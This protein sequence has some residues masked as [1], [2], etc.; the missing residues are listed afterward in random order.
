MNAERRAEGGA[1]SGVA[2]ASDPGGEYRVLVA[3]GNPAHAEQLVRTAADLARREGGSLFVVSVVLK[4]HGS[5]VALLDD[6]VIVEEFSGDRREILD[7]AVAT[8]G[9]GVTIE[10]EVRVGSDLARVL[11][12]AASD[13]DCDAILVGWRERSRTDAVFGS[14]VDRIVGR[15]P[16]DVL[17]ERIGP[18]ANG[19]SSVLLPV[20]DTPHAAL[21]AKV[22]DSIAGANDA[23]V[24]ALRVVGP[25]AG[26]EER[27][28]EGAL[29]DRVSQ[30]LSVPVESSL[31]ESDDIAGTIIEHSK[32]TDVTVLGAT[33]QRRLRRLVASDVPRAVGRDAHNTV[34]TTK[35]G[36][37]ESR[38]TRL[39]G[40]WGL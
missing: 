1:E 21:A 12:R 4:Q 7:R 40:G 27:R 30:S 24:L 22:A 16:C 5:P 15:A 36:G 25:G 9:D 18:T 37:D 11:L 28:E 6:D 10:G 29:L 3:L 8:V 19:V 39:L 13:H 32:E 23:T 33:G 31:V 26:D 35:R 2:A 20:A 14:N 17:V 38:L 34:I